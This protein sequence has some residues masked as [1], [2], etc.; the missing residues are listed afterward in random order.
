M[1]RHLKSLIFDSLNFTECLITTLSTTDGEAPAS[2]KR[3]TISVLSN[4][5]A[6]W[7]NVNFMNISDEKLLFYVTMTSELFIKILL[8]YKVM[9]LV[10]I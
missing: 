7:E 2:N 8:Q 3:S 5:T 10:K 6:S 1:T 4:L 9:L